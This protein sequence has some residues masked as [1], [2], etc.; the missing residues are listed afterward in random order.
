M[1]KNGN[2]GAALPYRLGPA[3]GNFSTLFRSHQRPDFRKFSRFG[4][5]DANSTQ[6]RQ[7]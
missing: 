6:T 7:R 4:S 2:I 5:G 3:K 1:I